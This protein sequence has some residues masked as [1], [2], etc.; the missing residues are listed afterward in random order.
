MSGGTTI[1]NMDYDNEQVLNISI[2]DLPKEAKALVEKAVQQYR[3]KCL[4]SFTKMRDKVIQK[5][6]LPRTLFHGQRDPDVVAEQNAMAE[7]ISKTMTATLTN[8]INKCDERGH[9]RS[10]NSSD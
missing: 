8:H 6:M 9:V 4:S 10:S 2:D 3:D 7:T 5:T 1:V